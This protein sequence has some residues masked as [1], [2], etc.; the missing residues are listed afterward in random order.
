MES[1]INNLVNGNNE[2]AKEQAKQFSRWEIREALVEFGWSDKKATACVDWLG[3]RD[4]WQAYC[5]AN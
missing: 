2:T 5:D 3:G 1:L 4:W